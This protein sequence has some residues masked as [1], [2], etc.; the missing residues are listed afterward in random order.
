MIKEGQNLGQYI[1]ELRQ[2]KVITLRAM[3]EALGFSAAYLS[4][5][6]LNRR[7]PSRKRIAQV[8]CYFYE[9]GVCANRRVMFDAMLEMAG[10][11]SRERR[12]LIDMYECI[13][14]SHGKCSDLD[15]SQMV[16]DIGAALWRDVLFEGEK[17]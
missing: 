9:L 2:T 13:K 12:A 16:Q 5:V 10:Q 8:V 17:S 15:L 14:S 1:R 6:E 7:I 4:D 3:A 11:M